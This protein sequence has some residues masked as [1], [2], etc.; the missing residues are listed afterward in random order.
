MTAHNS[1]AP[2]RRRTLL[3]GAA[4][5]LL[6]GIAPTS[7]LAQD[8]S[9][10]LVIMQWQG[11]TEAEMW[12]KLEEAFMAKH[13]GVTVRELVRHR[14]GRHARPDAHRADGRR[15]RRHHHQHLAGF[16]R[17]THRR[18][19]SA[20]RSTSSGTTYGWSDKLSQSWRDLGS[21]DGKTYGV[22][23]TYGD[24]SGIWYK[25]GHLEKAGIDAAQ[26]L[27]RV[28]RLASTS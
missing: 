5:A 20:A 7:A 11:G 3:A 24:R 10:E 2:V 18:R 22:T 27:G 4:M 15:S 16:P 26:D 17:R 14:P 28:P 8:V 21:I 13:P 6:L 25:P 19:H 12:K 1:A 9:G 23:Y